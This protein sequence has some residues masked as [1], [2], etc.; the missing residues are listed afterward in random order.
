VDVPAFDPR[1]GRLEV[2]WERL[3]QA[4][5][6][7]DPS[8]LGRWAHRIGTARLRHLLEN[9]P[10]E[11]VTR[12]RAALAALPF[13]PGSVRLCGAVASLA[14][15]PDAALATAAASTAGA[16]LA[17]DPHDLE[18]W[19][20]TAATI[21]ESCASLAA[22][23]EPGP[24][25]GVRR[26]ALGALARAAARCP[27][28]REALARDPDAE[29][30]RAAILALDAHGEDVD[31]TGA[32][33]DSDPQVVS[34]AAARACQRARAAGTAP[35]PALLGAARR[36]ARARTAVPEDVAELLDCLV[37]SSDPGDR[38]LLEKVAAASW[39]PVRRQAQSLLSA[40]AP[41]P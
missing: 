7:G 13:V 21:A 1:S 32:L 19:E 37:V 10:Q 3:E 12:L 38:K 36:F 22:A 9:H 16:L 11:P 28:P 29:V 15:H 23:T 35:A 30:R 40:S 33:M 4:A 34:A 8:A 41:A 14:T 5:A 2:P 26:A 39:A 18:T 31:L 25:G 6:A 17:S 24:A 27:P 20:V